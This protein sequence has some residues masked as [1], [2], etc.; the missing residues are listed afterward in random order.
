M[1][2]PPRRRGLTWKR[3]IAICAGVLAVALV[4]LLGL[5]LWERRQ[6]RRELDAM[7]TY[8]YTAP[9]VDSE[10]QERDAKKARIGK[11]IADAMAAQSTALLTGDRARFVS[12]AAPAYRL[13]RT[14]L[15]HSFTSL[16]AMGVAQWKPT[17]DYWTPYSNNRWQSNIVVDYCFVAGCAA[18]STIT[19]HTMWDLSDEKRPIIT[20]LWEYTGGQASPPW[21]Q[22]VL[23]AKI[24]SRVI[25]A[26]SAATAGRLSSVLAKAE[27]A[28]RVADQYAH[29]TK[30]GKYVVYLAGSK[31]WGTW[32]Y[33]EEGNWVAGYAEPERESVVLRASKAGSAFLPELLR[34]ELGHVSTLAGQVPKVKYA[35][36]WW[37]IEGMADYVAAQNRPFAQY[38]DRSLTVSFVRNKWN[39]D[40]RIARPAKKASLADANGRYGT[41]YLGVSCLVQQVGRAKA[42]GFFHAVAV[43]GIPLTTAA[44]KQL[45]VSWPALSSTC[46]AQIRR[47][48]R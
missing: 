4:V 39:G 27:A 18:S 34:H 17:I 40:L 43:E 7:P 44:T 21:A 46:T 33:S 31:E 1:P 12:Y 48:A 38:S 35:D 20:E 37:L 28:A 36:A 2:E 45:G 13:G 3:A 30:P 5:G 29:T 22:S 14:W 42:L 24:G 9:R 6:V 26:G 15:S 41:A 23:R 8:A 32:P 11:A 19:L 47:T 10:I 25:V 16:R